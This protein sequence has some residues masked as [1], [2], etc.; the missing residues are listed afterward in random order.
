MRAGVAKLDERGLQIGGAEHDLL[1]L[2][3]DAGLTEPKQVE[4]IEKLLNETKNG[5]M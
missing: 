4:R 2:L 5:C 3:D 1:R